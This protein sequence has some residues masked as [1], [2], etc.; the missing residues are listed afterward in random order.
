ML[1]NEDITVIEN[2]LHRMLEET[3]GVQ[4]LHKIE[5]DYVNENDVK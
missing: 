3:Q 2:N 5:I 1:L 4:K